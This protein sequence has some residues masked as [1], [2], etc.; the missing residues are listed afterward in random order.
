MLIFYIILALVAIAAVVFA[1]KAGINFTVVVAGLVL[2]LLVPLPV[3]GIVTSIAKNSQETYNQYYNGFETAAT[4]TAQTCDRDGYCVHNYDCDPYTVVYY[5]TVTDSDGKGSHQE[6]RTKTEYHS[7]PY[8]KQETSYYVQTTLGQ[9]TIAANA[10]TGAPYR[11]SASIPGGQVKAPPAFWSKVQ[12][13][14][15]AGAP[16]GVTQVNTYKNFILASQATVLHKYSDKIAALKKAKLIPVPTRSTSNFYMADKA[17]FVG[18]TYGINK[19]ALSKSVMSLNGAVGTELQGDVRIVFANSTVVGDPQTY[20]NAL[21]ADWENPKAYDRDALA[22]NTI[23]III[24]VSPDKTVAWV[25]GFTGM[26]VGNEGMVTDLNYN[27]LGAPVNADLVGTPTY[28]VTTK[29]VVHSNGKIESILFGANKFQ[30]VSMSSKDK[31]DHGTGFTYLADDWAPDAGTWAI[32]F[33]IASVLFLG[34]GFI[35]FMFG[36]RTDLADPARR[37]VS[38]VTNSKQRD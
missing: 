11:S 14:V 16:G 2:A 33:I 7:C 30:R 34:V 9:Y 26:P 28:N 36:S 13:R 35:G 29:A 5:V 24:G 12:A 22:K 15:A 17:Q 3:Y 32:F 10:M 20:G 37:F 19:T 4:K 27:L 8:S 6:M 21:M 31:T 1:Y 18:D 25:R 23:V 38:V